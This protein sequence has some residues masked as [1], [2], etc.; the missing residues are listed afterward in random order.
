MLLDY[1]KQQQNDHK[2]RHV[3]KRKLVLQGSKHFG[4]QVA[5]S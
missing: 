1:S 4:Q 3:N 5:M 2:T